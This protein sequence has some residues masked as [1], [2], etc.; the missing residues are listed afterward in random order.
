MRPA[1]PA[2]GRASSCRLHEGQPANAAGVSL[3]VAGLSPAFH[4]VDRRV[5]H[6]HALFQ[7]PFCG[8]PVPGCRCDRTSVVENVVGGDLRYGDFLRRF[9]LPAAVC[10]APVLSVCFMAPFLDGSL[11]KGH[12]VSGDGGRLYGSGFPKS[13]RS[14]THSGQASGELP[15]VRPISRIL[16]RGNPPRPA[17]LPTRAGGSLPNR[18]A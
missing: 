13:N 4:A 5:D 16:R 3:H 7:L 18:R 2:S 9:R 17:V 11:A 6:H 1:A 14:C 15:T 10:S 8:R 12:T